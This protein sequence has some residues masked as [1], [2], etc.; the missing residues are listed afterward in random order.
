MTEQ[1]RPPETP[2]EWIVTLTCCG[3]DDGTLTAGTWEQADAIRE[4]YT[5]GVAVHPHGYSA[6]AHESGHRRSA[7]V[8]RRLPADDAMDTA[9]KVRTVFTGTMCALNNHVD[10]SDEALRVAARIIAQAA[11]QA[12]ERDNLRRV[13]ELQQADL[14]TH[15]VA[16]ER[17]SESHTNVEKQRDRALAREQEARR[18][19]RWLANLAFGVGLDGGPP[20]AGEIEDAA[21]AAVAFLGLPEVKG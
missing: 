20:Q 5:S 15:K 2:A 16:L 13:I 7:V 21:G 11:P 12:Q 3:R 1:E 6:P 18:L 10:E 19:L 4:S 8:S 9:L 17:L 14:E